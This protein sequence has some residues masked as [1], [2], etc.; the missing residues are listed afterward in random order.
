MTHFQFPH[1]LAKL[2]ISLEVLNW[3]DTP[4]GGIGISFASAGVDGKGC[5]LG[6]GADLLDN[7]GLSSADRQNLPKPGTMAIL[8]LATVTLFGYKQPRWQR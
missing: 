8:G 7:F 3:S 1:L 4:V 5:L 2:S 6:V